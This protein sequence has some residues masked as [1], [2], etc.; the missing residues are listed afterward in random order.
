MCHFW[1]YQY[2][3]LLGSFVRGIKVMH[4]YKNNSNSFTLLFGVMNVKLCMAN[5]NP[6][7]AA[8][9]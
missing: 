9:L 3:K 8:Q 2:K 1:T 7:I 5:I 6:I 4:H